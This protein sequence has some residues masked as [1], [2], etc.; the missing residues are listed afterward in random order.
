[1]SVSKFIRLLADRMLRMPLPAGISDGGSAKPISR[2]IIFGKF[3][4]PTYDYYFAA[5]MVAANMPTFELVDVRDFSP[6]TDPFG[7]FIIIIRYGSLSLSRWIRRNR[8]V[9]SGVVVFV[10]D[11]IA[12]AVTSPAA[13]WRYRYRLMLQSIFPL[14][15]LDGK[16]DEVWVSTEVLARRLSYTAPRL[17]TPAPC[18]EANMIQGRL[19]PGEESPTTTIAYHATAIHSEEHR[20]L[21]PI[22]ASVLQARASVR[23]EVVATGKSAALWAR[24]DSE[25]VNVIKPLP[26]DKYLLRQTKKKID[27]MVVPVAPSRL[28]ECRADTKRIDV[29]RVGA[30]AVFSECDAFNPAER[31]EIFLPYR[32]DE[33]VKCLIE[34]IDDNEMRKATAESTRTRVEK[35]ARQGALGISLIRQRVDQAGNQRRS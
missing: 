30:A 23:F 26:W 15:F 5:R 14:R 28:N 24:L 21:V 11:D 33:W 12:A 13:G 32:R 16:I 18:L 9:L 7:A 3:P 31:D 1:M 2:V 8:A 22:I 35:M 6:Q 17:L 34:L 4:N 29:A 27:I 25:R 19:I 20:F 10:D